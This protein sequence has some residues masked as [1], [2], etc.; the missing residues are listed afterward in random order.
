MEKDADTMIQ[1]HDQGVAARIV[2]YKFSQ[3]KVPQATVNLSPQITTYITGVHDLTG[4]LVTQ[5]GIRM[6]N[7]GSLAK[8]PTAT[9]DTPDSIMLLREPDQMTPQ[10]LER[11]MTRVASQF[12]QAEL[13]IQNEIY[14]PVDD[15]IT[16][17]WCGFRERC[18]D[19]LVDDFGAAE[20]RAK[21]LPP[22]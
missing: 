2:D 8:K 7:P 4:K 5:A 18:Q 14:I 16:C 3:R 1:H 19:S 22:T 6:M 17:S 12:A 15:P 13:L 11:R 20:I 21:T 10:A 9:S